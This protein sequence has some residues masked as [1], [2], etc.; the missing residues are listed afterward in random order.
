[1]VAFIIAAS[2]NLSPSARRLWLEFLNNCNY[3][4]QYTVECHSGGTVHAQL[5]RCLSSFHLNIRARAIRRG[6]RQGPLGH[7]SDSDS[8]SPIFC[9]GNTIP[10]T[11]IFTGRVLVNPN[12]LIIN[13]DNTG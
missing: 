13:A 6:T 11:C 12:G 1:M 4:T 8:L 2:A 7:I 5:W 9:H 3:E 10:L